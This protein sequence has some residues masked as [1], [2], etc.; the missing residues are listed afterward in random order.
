[1]GSRALDPDRG[2]IPRTRL[3]YY[4]KSHRNRS[5]LR[6][7]T[8]RLHLFGWVCALFLAL[9]PGARA[10]TPTSTSAPAGSSE[11]GTI[12]GTVT[13]R[14]GEAYEGV[15]VSLVIAS[16]PTTKTVETD[17]N[18]EFIFANL[19]A[20]R[21]SLTIA[22]QGFET[23]IVT[24]ELHPGENWDAHNVVLPLKAATSEVRVS[25]AAQAEIAEQQIHIEEQQRVLGVLPN[26]YVSYEKN[27]IPLTSRQKFQ[28]A[29]RSSVDPLTFLLTGIFAGV[30]QAGNTFAGYGQGMQGYGK[31]YG[32]LY[33]DTA[34]SNEIGGAVL[35]SLLRQDPRYLYKGT[36]TIGARAGY[37]IASA[38]VCRGDNMHWQFNYSS[39]LGGLAAAGISNLYYPRSERSGVQEVF[40]NL[41]IGLA[42]N[43]VQNLLQEFVVKK[44]TPS[45]RKTRSE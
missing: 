11:Q 7:C 28:L 36:G 1:M 33:A 10:Q 5:P 24:G 13:G 43:A 12:S 14:D 42:G 9:L 32:A 3:I 19:P 39:L 15:S 22:S 35:P 38:I 41:S 16:V 40:E 29:T 20:G 26:Y 37:A 4:G 6:P 31:R 34:I 2:Q 8:L 45:A 25:A 18:G 30:E 27:P 21:F 17:P 23:Q 44:L